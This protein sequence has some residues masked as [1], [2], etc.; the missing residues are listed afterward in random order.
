M[1]AHEDI[2]DIIVASLKDHEDVLVAMSKEC[3]EKHGA[4]MLMWLKERYGNGQG[5]CVKF[6]I[7]TFHCEFTVK[8][9]TAHGFHIDFTHEISANI[10]ITTPDPK[11]CSVKVKSCIFTPL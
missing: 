3:D 11:R 8:Y 1:E 7:F 10:Q 9:R 4:K 5:S 6:H 2:A